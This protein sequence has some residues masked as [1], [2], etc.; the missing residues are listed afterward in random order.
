MVKSTKRCLRKVLG[1]ACFE[2]LTAVTEIESIINSHPLSYVS[3]DDT[4][5]ALRPSH[6]LIG[7]RVWNLLHNYRPLV[8]S[9][10]WRLRYWLHS[11]EQA[12]KA[13]KWHTHSFLVKMVAGVSSWIMGRSPISPQEIYW[14]SSSHSRRY[15]HRPWWVSP[16]GILE[17]GLYPVSDFEQDG[18][19]RGAAVDLMSRNGQSTITL[20]RPLQKLY[21]LEIK[22]K[23]LDVSS[24]T[25]VSVE[26]SDHKQSSQETRTLH[27]HRDVA[28]R[29]KEQRREW[30]TQDDNS[31]WS[32][33]NH[34]YAWPMVG[35][36]CELLLTLNYCH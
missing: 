21:P 2:M 15:C 7:C 36:C 35:R 31:D 9:D 27:P 5:E 16:L 11:V 33:N 3:A 6:L 4:V 1:R 12:Y 13:S 22:H 24:T 18:Q 20:N 19:V 25:D 30:M 34:I 32:V 17:V 14:Q 10:W 23:P 8:W 28:V 29:C 26:P